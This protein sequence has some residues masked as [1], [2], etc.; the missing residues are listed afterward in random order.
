MLD[1][2]LERS[3]PEIA[4]IRDPKIR[5]LCHAQWRYVSEHGDPSHTD[6]E[7]IPIHPSLPVGRYGAL[8][9]HIRGQMEISKVLVPFAKREWKLELDL[10][11]FLACALVH[12]SAKVIEFVQKDGQLVPTPGFD[13]AAEG[14]KIALTVG[15]PKEVAHMIAVHTYLGPRRLPRTAAAQLFQ[16]LDPICLPVFPEGGK[17]AVERHLEANGWSVPPS[18]AEVP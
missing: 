3:F 11:H 2:Q 6:I 1:R 12:D 4:S 14:A 8:S 13:H 18:P 10:D 5:E 7:K 16:F 17:S 9:S 15:F